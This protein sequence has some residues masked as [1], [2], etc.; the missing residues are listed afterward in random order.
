MTPALLEGKV[1]GI[2]LI[3]ATAIL[4]AGGMAF[5]KF[6]SSEPQRR[7]RSERSVL[8]RAAAM[9]VAVH[10]TEVI[11]WIGYFVWRHSIPDASAVYPTLLRE[12]GDLSLLVRW[13]L[14]T[15]GMALLTLLWS[16]VVLLSLSRRLED[17]RSSGNGRDRNWTAP[18]Q[19]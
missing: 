8:L 19:T 10:L 9:I 6:A 2:V 7:A 4:H 5:V 1:W 18:G 17:A 16:A 3:L 11:L 15:V 14:L 13:Q 12:S